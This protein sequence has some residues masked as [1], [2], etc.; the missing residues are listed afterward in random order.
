MRERVRQ[1]AVGVVAVLVLGGC[2]GDGSTT[3][4]VVEPLGSEE[5]ASRV[6]GRPTNGELSEI[7]V[8][9]HDQLP[10]GRIP[11]LEAEIAA[12][13]GVRAV[14]FVSREEAFANV[15]E[16]FADDPLILENVTADV[17]FTSFIVSVAPDADQRA[18]AAALDRLDDVEQV[19]RADEL[20]PSFGTTPAVTADLLQIYWRMDRLGVALS[21]PDVAADL[22]ALPPPRQGGT[23]RCTSHSADL[24]ACL[25]LLPDGRRLDTVLR[26]EGRSW[27]VDHLTVTDGPVAEPE[28]PT[29]LDA[30]AAEDR[31]AGRPLLPGADL[32][33]YLLDGIADADQAALRA[34][35]EEDPR[36]T[37]VRYESKEEALVLA[38]HLFGG[39]PQVLEGL[40]A[41]DLPASFRVFL[42]EGADG[43]PLR[44]ELR[45]ER[46][47][48]D[49]IV[50]TSPLTAGSPEVGADLLLTL[51]R[52]DGLSTL[53]THL[54]PG[55]AD[56]QPPEEGGAARCTVHRPDEL[57]AC[58]QALP[59]GRRI[60]TVVRHD[61]A[62]WVVDHVEIT[63]EGT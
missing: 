57:A 38:R 34:R 63:D 21:A 47:V 6:A 46:G 44:E 7:S 29:P 48:D 20:S 11:A 27:W 1:V 13:P 45:D 25:Q 62:H 52:A 8:F 59:D 24:A 9:L 61:G 42:V 31:V 5:A 60:D 22:A 4:P 40:T 43:A 16:V 32:S 2:T 51:W 39:D 28:S 56:H 14:T 36:I 33:V 58:A 12:L 10:E 17:L 15:Q 53:Q 55:L 35:L 3:A 50:D 30:A 54:L 49:V 18:L 37:S 41:A 23:A 19:R 26:R